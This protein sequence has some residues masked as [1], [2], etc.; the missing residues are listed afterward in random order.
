MPSC[1]A[2]RT[3]NLE[4][5]ELSVVTSLV[6]GG[7]LRWG[8]GIIWSFCS[9]LGLGEEMGE[10][11]GEE[12]QKCGGEAHDIPLRRRAARVVQ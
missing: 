7:R 11:T 5:I 6:R 1:G 4:S 12:S 3:R 9:A 2:L 10:E 8:I